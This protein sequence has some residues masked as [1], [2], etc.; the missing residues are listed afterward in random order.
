MISFLEI[1]QGIIEVRGSQAPAHGP[2]I[3]SHPGC[4]LDHGQWIQSTQTDC[5][6]NPTKGHPWA[7]GCTCPL[8]WVG[9]NSETLMEGLGCGIGP[10]V[11]WPLGR[12]GCLSSRKD[13]ACG[14]S[15]KSPWCEC[16]GQGPFL[17]EI[18]G[19]SGKMDLESFATRNLWPLVLILKLAIT[20][21]IQKVEWDAS[22]YKC[23]GIQ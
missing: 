21:N 23:I 20:F 7:E 22:T 11:V 8:P 12:Y 13:E 1:S 9:Q 15:E 4:I 17:P 5:S 2:Y 19:D 6:M 16:P 10:C 3:G 14:G 18:R